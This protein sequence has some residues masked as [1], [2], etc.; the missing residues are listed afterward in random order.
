MKVTNYVTDRA[1]QQTLVE[2]RNRMW[3][4][5]RT[6]STAVVAALARDTLLVEVDAIVALPR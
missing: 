2:T 4:E 6:A 1:Y 3:G 5:L